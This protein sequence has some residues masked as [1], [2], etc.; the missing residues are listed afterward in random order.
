MFSIADFLHSCCFLIGSW[1]TDPLNKAFGRKKT[2][3]ITCAI[4]FYF[5]PLFMLSRI[6]NSIRL[7]A[8]LPAFGVL[9]PIPGGIYL[10]QDFSLALV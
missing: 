6:L 8:S 5:T 4:R 7:L 9:S 1:L 10:L 3:F 2:I